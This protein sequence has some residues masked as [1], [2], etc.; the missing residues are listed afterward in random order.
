[1]NLR[2]RRS[3]PRN[4]GHAMMRLGEASLLRWESL[5]RVPVLSRHHRRTRVLGNEGNWDR[6]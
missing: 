5:T 4:I 3:L 6:I 2:F 1:M